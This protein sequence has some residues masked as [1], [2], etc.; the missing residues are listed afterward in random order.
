MPDTVITRVNILGKGQPSQLTFKDRKGR[1]IGDVELTGVDVQR[2]P[3]I[4]QNDDNGD[5]DPPPLLPRNPDDDLPP[6]IP[7]KP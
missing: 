6:L 3:L 2:E 7:R 4:A 1:P 5:D